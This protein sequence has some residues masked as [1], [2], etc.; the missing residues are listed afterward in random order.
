M[1]LTVRQ[2]RIP[3]ARQATAGSWGG[4]GGAEKK[5]AG[6][7]VRASVPPTVEPGRVFAL[8]Q[9]RLLLPVVLQEASRAG[10]VDEFL[11]PAQPS[12]ACCRCRPRARRAA[13]RVAAPLPLGRAFH[14]AGHVWL[15]DAARHSYNLYACPPAGA[16][17]P[18]TALLQAAAQH[19]TR[20]PPT[21]RPFAIFRIYRIYAC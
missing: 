17:E 20:M 14:S 8:D 5:G 16:I 18:Q 2:K 19:L 4:K 3:T 12:R 11:Q 21:V 13:A 15:R 9:E 7:E 1:G 6:R 10:R